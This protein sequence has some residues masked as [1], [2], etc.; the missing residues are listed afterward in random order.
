MTGEQGKDRGAVCV[1]L[2]TKFGHLFHLGLGTT[3]RYMAAVVLLIAPPVTAEDDG[4]KRER[5]GR[6][7]GRDREKRERRKSE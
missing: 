5:R 7:G 6:E 4:G 2:N 1:K 3:L